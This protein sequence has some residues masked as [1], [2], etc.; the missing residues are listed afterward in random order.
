MP[1]NFIHAPVVF[2]VLLVLRWSQRRIR[3]GELAGFVAV[4]ARTDSRAQQGGAN[5]FASGATAAGGGADATAGGGAGRRRRCCGRFGSGEWRPPISTTTRVSPS[6]IWS[7]LCGLVL[8]TF[9][10]LTIARRRPEIDDEDLVGAGDLDH[11]MHARDAVVFDAQMAGRRLA[12]LDDVARELR[13]GAAPLH[14]R[15]GKVIGI[16]VVTVASASARALGR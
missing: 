3:I 10:P 8:L 5:G 13:S 2:A 6:W 11:R 16:F 12:D 4:A 15:C 7:P 9:L 1:Q 14:D